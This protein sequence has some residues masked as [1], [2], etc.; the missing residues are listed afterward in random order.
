M[1]KQW[2]I[3]FCAWTVVIGAV[4]MCY[5]FIQHEPVQQTSNDKM[6]MKANNLTS[7]LN[8]INISKEYTVRCTNPGNCIVSNKRIKT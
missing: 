3:F 6:K 8:N 1:I 5:S 4:L 7:E 2:L